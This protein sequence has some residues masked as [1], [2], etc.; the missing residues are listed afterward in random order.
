M[1]RN[2][3]VIVAFVA[4]PSDLDEERDKLDEIVR[5]LNITWSKTL[6]VRLDLVRFE[7]DAMPGVGADPQDVINQQLG[8]DFDIFIGMMWGRFG[9]PTGRAGSGTEEE[10]LRARKRYDAGGGIRLMLYF[11]DAP[12]APSEIDPTQLA[13]VR[14]FKDSL[15]DKGILH[16]SFKNLEEFAQ[17]LR[18]HL[19]KQIQ[20][21]AGVSAAPAPMQALKPEDQEAGSEDDEGYLDL[22][23]R[24]EAQ[25]EATNESTGRLT[26]MLQELN[27]SMEAHANEVTKA[28]QEDVSRAETK[29]LVNKSAETMDRATQRARAE[30]PLLRSGLTEAMKAAGKIGLLMSQ[31]PPEQP[32]VAAVGLRGFRDSMAGALEMTGALRGSIQGLP[33][34]TTRINQS[35]T[36]LAHALN[37]I[38]QV[39]AEGIRLADEALKLFHDVS[40][41]DAEHGVAPVDPAAGTSV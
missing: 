35:K 18:I 28:V 33:R 14:R 25:L 22:M 29:R 5:E 40:E 17:L 10:F 9:T 34:L 21:L 38:G 27:T 3:N 32:L 12:I 36:A 16:G 1:P 15:R 8:D 7:T 24:F 11:K 31:F 4:S 19:A 37:E 20:Q 13:E 30:S 26:E 39:F 41:P 2:E 6:K 23:E